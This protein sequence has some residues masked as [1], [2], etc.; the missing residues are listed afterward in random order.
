LTTTRGRELEKVFQANNYTS[1][2]TGSPTY[3]PLYVN[4]IP[5]LLDFFVISGLSPSYTDI[6][7]S[8]DLSSNHTS[9]V[10]TIS[11]SIATRIPSTRLHM[12]HTN[13]K[14]YQSEISDKLT[15]MQKL[16]TQEDIESA[17]ADLM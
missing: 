2:S 5:D 9:I 15:T 4:K 14:L 7:L 1:L 11:T 13:W 3:W 8:Y 12:S 10:A 17:T 6:Q 16:K